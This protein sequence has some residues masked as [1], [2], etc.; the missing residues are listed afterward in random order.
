[1]PLDSVLHRLEEIKAG[2][3]TLNGRTVTVAP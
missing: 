1:M 3:F 2:H